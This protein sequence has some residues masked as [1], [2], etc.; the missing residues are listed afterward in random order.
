MYAIIN[1]LLENTF[2]AYEHINDIKFIKIVDVIKIIINTGSIRYTLKIRNC[3]NKETIQNIKQILL[4]YSNRI[5]ELIYTH[6]NGKINNNL[7]YINNK[8]RYSNILSFK[9]EDVYINFFNKF[10]TK[11]ISEIQIQT[12]FNMISFNDVVIKAESL[13]FAEPSVIQLNF[14]KLFKLFSLLSQGDTRIYINPG[15]QHNFKIKHYFNEDMIFT[16]KYFN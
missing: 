2:K 6:K 7:I 4:L 16:C 9:N 8:P 5:G 15:H 13:R 10:D 11:N 1:T 12:N 3:D 14:L